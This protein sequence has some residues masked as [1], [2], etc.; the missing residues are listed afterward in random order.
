MVKSHWTPINHTGTKG[1]WIQQKRNPCWFFPAR[2]ENLPT[3]QVIEATW[4]CWARIWKWKADMGISPPM[5]QTHRNSSTKNG[6]LTRMMIQ[7]IKWERYSDT[8]SEGK[9]YSIPNPQSHKGI[10]LQS[11]TCWRLI[12]QFQLET[13]L[14]LSSKNGDLNSK[15]VG[16]SLQKRGSH[17]PHFIK[18]GGSQQV[19]LFRG[20]IIT[21]HGWAP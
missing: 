13:N 16:S 1:G 4:T 18:G 20:S 2:I 19:H 9:E 12:S 14:N 7:A 10:H 8:H 5:S 11:D 17:Q 6:T 15:H 21:W 3:I